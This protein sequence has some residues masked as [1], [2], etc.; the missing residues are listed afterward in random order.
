LDHQVVVVLMDTAIIYYLDG[1]LQGSASMTKSET[2]VNSIADLG[3]STAW[4][5]RGGYQA[6]PAWCGKVYQFT[7]YDKALSE[8][9]IQFLFDKGK[10]VVP[11]FPQ[12]GT[13]TVNSQASDYVYVKNDKIHV[14]LYLENTALVEFCVYNSLGQLMAN[15]KVKFGAGSNQAV[16]KANLNKGI[17]FVNMSQNGKTTT[18]KVIK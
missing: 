11:Q 16:L 5:G 3:T 12:V 6:D 4:I 15:Q 9:E 17:Y 18:F 14:K 2:E 7:I 10:D 8:A 1:V 13:A